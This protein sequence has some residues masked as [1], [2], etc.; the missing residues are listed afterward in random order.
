MGTRG[1]PSTPARRSG[2]LL[3]ALVNLALLYLIHVR[4]GGQA[5][6]FLTEDTVQV[7][8]LVDASILVGLAANVVYLARDDTWVR[9][10][11]DLLT[12]GVGL[13]ALARIWT[14]YP[15]D[16]PDTDLPWDLL[17]RTVLFFAVA[18]SVVGMLVALVRL[19]RAVG[20]GAAPGDDPAA[21]RSRTAP[22]GTGRRGAPTRGQE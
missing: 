13:A 2:Y 20:G 4:P 7:L 14:V 9:A 5:V 15:F 11:G 17:T 21:G 1:A 16:L 12:T 10:L 8:G 19:V 22:T 18:G 3:G 6:P